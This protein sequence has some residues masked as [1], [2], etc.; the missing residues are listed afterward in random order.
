VDFVAPLVLTAIA[1]FTG[2]LYLVTGRIFG[3]TAAILTA[4][5]FFLFTAWRWWSF[6]LLRGLRG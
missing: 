4:T 1:V 3:T 6:A 2:V 5:A